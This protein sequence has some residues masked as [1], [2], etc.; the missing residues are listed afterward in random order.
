[1]SSYF[2]S[3]FNYLLSHD[4]DENKEDEDALFEAALEELQ[5]ADAIK[6]NDFVKETDMN[7][8]EIANNKNCFRKT[9]ESVT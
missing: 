2:T 6:N 1:M 5:I 3:F 7:A 8:L 9:G 4:E